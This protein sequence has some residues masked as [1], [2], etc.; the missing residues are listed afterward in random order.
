MKGSSTGLE[1]IVGMV[2]FGL[3]EEVRNL[4]V[5]ASEVEAKRTLCGIYIRDRYE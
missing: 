4:L 3:F 1:Q 5:R 2:P